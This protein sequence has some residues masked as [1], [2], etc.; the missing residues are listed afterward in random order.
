M[1][2]EGAGARM[3]VPRIG[4]S[5]G[6]ILQHLKRGG[7]GTIPEMARALELSVETVRTHLRALGSEG[8]VERR[9]R[10]GS[11]PGRPE[12]V[13]G[14]TAAAEEL[15]PSQEGKLLQDL[16][17]FLEEQ[18][19]ADLLRAFFE[20]Q[21][22]RRRAALG[23]RLE[24]LGDDERLEEVA[25]VLTEEGFMADVVTDEDGRKLLRLSHCPLRNLVDVTALPCRAELEV[26]QEML[27]ERL[28]R[29][30]YIPSGDHACCYAP[31]GAER[32]DGSGPTRGSPRRTSLP[33]R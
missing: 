12:I 22:A 7:S 15:F 27:G 32:D 19:R 13:Y 18:G 14:L 33:I 16:A 3:L 24:R 5:Q 17:A 11:G 1:S 4:E 20:E 2:G 21:T 31:G 10:R 25:R 28:S 26:V 29:V 30:S 9:G 6:R 23:T 8:L